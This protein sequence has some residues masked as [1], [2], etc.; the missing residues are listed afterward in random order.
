MNQN[1]QEENTGSYR[2]FLLE[3][4]ECSES[5]EEEVPVII[6]TCWPTVTGYVTKDPSSIQVAENAN[7]NLSLSLT[8]YSID[9]E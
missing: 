3:K 2:T 4:S 1:D 7:I 8:V 5:T 9:E 6:G